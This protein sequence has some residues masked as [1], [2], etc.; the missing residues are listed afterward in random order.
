HR[1]HFGAFDALRE[2]HTAHTGDRDTL[3]STDVHL[4]ARHDDA[5]FT[6]AVADI[7]GARLRAHVDPIDIIDPHL[8]ADRRNAN[9]TESTGEVNLA[10]DCADCDVAAVGATNDYRRRGMVAPDLG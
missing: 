3:R 9:G 7:D 8:A 2:D 4:G 10:G 1:L 6:F 5:T